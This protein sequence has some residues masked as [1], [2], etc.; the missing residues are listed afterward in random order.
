MQNTTAG[1]RAMQ[2]VAGQNPHHPIRGW[3]GGT[4]GH[5]QAEVNSPRD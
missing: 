5:G 3:A 1:S 4:Q 2:M